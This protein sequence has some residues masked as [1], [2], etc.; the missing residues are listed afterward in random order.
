MNM[1]KKIFSVLALLV[2]LASPVAAFAHEVYV[3]TP[4]EIAM[5]E[6]A[7]TISPISIIGDNVEQFIFWTFVVLFTVITVFFISISRKIE[8]MFDPYLMRLKHYA[9]AVSRITIG[10]SFLAA[11]YY[12]AS[13][14]PELPFTQTFGE[15]APLVTIVVAVIGLLITIGFWTQFAALVALGLYAFAVVKYGSYMLTYANYLGE[16]VMLLLLGTH[17]LGVERFRSI[18]E[19]P[20]HILDVLARKF[21]PYGFLFLRVCFGISL[22]FAS[23]YAKFIYSNL[24]FQVVEK[25]NLVHF[26]PFEPHF[27]VLGAALLELTLGVFFILGIEIRFAVI[28]LNIFLALSM[29]YFGEAVWPHLILFGVSIALF[30]HGY[31]KYSIEGYFFK[32]GNREPV[33]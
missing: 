29:L 32:K 17:R 10:L 7:P 15:Y 5:A 26:F 27:L 23:V 20:R 12:Q 22:V 9:P 33:F 11:A 14:G 13:Y 8:D 24:A 1:F 21:A 31:D 28:F 4:D 19:A 16:I 18:A 3:L 6:A 30:L 25:Y 2:A